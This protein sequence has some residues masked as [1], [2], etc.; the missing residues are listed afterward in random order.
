M[1][2]LEPSQ[3]SLSLFSFP[4]S[5]VFVDKHISV[6]EIVTSFKSNGYKHASLIIYVYHLTACG[7]EALHKIKWK[8]L[9]MWWDII[10]C[11]TNKQEIVESHRILF[12]ESQFPWDVILWVLKMLPTFTVITS[13]IKF[14]KFVCSRKDSVIYLSCNETVQMQ[15]FVFRV[16]K[17]TCKY[18]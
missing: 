8:L 12:Q 4:T 2:S 16:T 1:F 13:W 14:I 18:I 15:M 9:K 11:K 17:Y 10:F 7:W 3:D 5:F 6:K